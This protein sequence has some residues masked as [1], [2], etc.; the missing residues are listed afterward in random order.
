MLV[1]GLIVLNICNCEGLFITQTTKMKR[2]ERMLNLLL[3]RLGMI[4]LLCCFALFAEAQTPDT[5][6]ITVP[7]GSSDTLCPT[8]DDLTNIDS[9][10]WVT[11]SMADPI[12]FGNISNAPI[13]PI[14][15]RCY[16]YNAGFQGGMHED[17]VCVVGYDSIGVPDTTMF[18]LSVASY[19][20]DT[21]Y[22]TVP[23]GDTILICATGDDIGNLDSVQWISCIGAP[24][25][26]AILGLYPGLPSS[27]FL[28]VG[29]PPTLGY[30]DSICLIGYSS[31]SP[32][33]TIWIIQTPATNDTIYATVLSGDTMLLCATGEDILA[34][35]SA[36]FV[37]CKGSLLN[38]M[39]QGLA[40]SPADS[41]LV[42][43]GGP[44]TSLFE[45]TVCVV[46]WSGGFSDTTVWI[47]STPP[48]TIPDT[49]YYSIPVMQTTD[50]LCPTADDLPMVNSVIY[51]ACA[52]S[53]DDG[54][55]NLATSSTPPG[56]VRYT[57]GNLAGTYVDTFC[58]VAVSPGGLLDTTVVVMSI[59]CDTTQ[60][61]AS[62]TYSQDTFCLNGSVILPYDTNIV[63]DAYT[64][65]P[66][67]GTFLNANNGA[68]TLDTSIAQGIYT[69][70]HITSAPCADTA[71][72]GIALFDIDDAFFTYPQTNYCTTDANPVPDS[73]TILG[74]FFYSD[75]NILVNAATGE[76]DLSS[77]ISNNSYV[78]KYVT[79]G[80]HPDTAA[81]TI[82]INNIDTATFSYPLDTF[83]EATFGP[84]PSRTGGVFTISRHLGYGPGI[85]IIDSVTG[86]VDASSD[87][88]RYTITH[89]TSSNGINTC[90]QTHSDTL[91]IDSIRTSYFTYFN[92]TFCIDGST[93]TPAGL[94][95]P[96]GT[97]TTTTGL[98]IDANAGYID[99]VAGGT[100]QGVHIIT[101]TSNQFNNCSPSFVDTLVLLNIDSAAFSYPVDTICEA[102]FG[103]PP[104]R[105]GGVFTIAPIPGTG[106]GIATINAFTGIVNNTSD[107]GC[108]FITHTTSGGGLGSCGQ[109]Y[110]DTLCI[111]SIHT[112]NFSFSNDTFCIDGS[113]I[114]P[115]GLNV[116]GHMYGGVFTATNGVTIDVD[117]GYI[118][119]VV[120]APVGITNVT[121]VSNQFRCYDTTTIALFLVGIDSA[122]F[123][124]PVDTICIG[125][126]GPAPSKIG[127]VFTISG[128]GIINPTTGVIDATT[129]AGVYTITHTTTGV[130]PSFCGDIHSEIITVNSFTGALRDT[131]VST[132]NQSVLVKALWN[133]T[134]VAFDSV[135]ITSAATNGNATYDATDS[136]F[137][138]TGN[139]N[140]VGVD[141]FEYS[142]WSYG[143]N[144]SA[145]VIMLIDTLALCSAHCIWPG[146]ANN[147]GVANN[148]D[149]VDIGLNYNLVA[150]PRFDQSI[151]WYAHSAQPWPSINNNLAHNDCDGNGI[152]NHSDTT[153][154]SVNYGLT[155]SKGGSLSAGPFDPVLHVDNPDSTLIP[156]SMYNFAINLGNMSI[157]ANNSY[158]LAFT[159]NYNPALIDT[160]SVSIDFTNSWLG[161]IN[162]LVYLYKDFHSSGKVEIG[163]SRID[164]SNVSG[165][166][167]IGTFGFITEENLVGK[168]FTDTFNFDI[169]I[170]NVRYVNAAGNLKPVNAIV[171]NNYLLPISDFKEAVE[172]NVYPNPA[173]NNL[174]L[175]ILDESNDNYLELID[176]NG[177][178]VYQAEITNSITNIELNNYAKGVY[179][180]RVVND[181]GAAIK[182]VII[183]E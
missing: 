161:G 117:S 124:Y 51:S 158:G 173:E 15:Y 162:D 80:F 180:I 8:A 85:G 73:V 67:L 143:C 3:C 144:S 94:N 165:F 19:P 9:V 150:V 11:C 28:Y 23:S 147:D 91:L 166:G 127:G 108:Y 149:I 6:W 153:A 110:T 103:P 107:P 155:H 136:T 88:G 69:I 163:L 5:M 160:N 119:L 125:T 114:Y 183:T 81:F 12:D 123:S 84:A 70:R 179:F 126:A 152:V 111:D 142:V 65:T 154:V 38:G 101:Y 182:K 49:V 98:V 18:I 169:T 102:T 50:T 174:T 25:N 116:P 48:S 146:D 115:V 86:I 175:Q 32:D 47:I 26:G 27:C 151:G 7:P 22:A 140:F 181:N 46:G 39:V 159:I 59:E 78:I 148:F 63:N 106:A 133:D 120:G 74:G 138:Y 95:V 29:G 55:V 90:G 37:H 17:T 156:D 68:I 36:T 145:W 157:P 131:I 4:I 176:L 24:L 57:A 83:C 44:S 77:A 21:Q 58:L 139:T 43:V 100:P 135:S 167:Q 20:S 89:T 75:S 16:V 14:G 93:I 134:M 164:H 61:A 141:S 13:G 1:W 171:D 34:A 40:L 168:M 130:T 104:S 33:T 129:P 45:D 56:C 170:S 97:F 96:G 112:S 2:M 53:I 30:V 121:Y 60:P 92:D 42:Y 109:S 99:L 76:V 71:Y 172:F 31:G 137:T 128:G 177:V 118:D 72:Y 79:I 113:R 41:C 178:V 64:A 87:P 35:D 52:H 54:F 62:F 105:T 132:I 66:S 10:I 122:E 82:S